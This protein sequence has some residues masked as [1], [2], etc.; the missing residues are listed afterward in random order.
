MKWHI[1]FIWFIN[2]QA[3]RPCFL[4]R[5]QTWITYGIKWQQNGVKIFLKLFLQ[6]YILL[7]LFSSRSTTWACH[8]GRHWRAALGGQGSRPVSSQGQAENGGSELYLNA[9]LHVR[10]LFHCLWTACSYY[11][12][13]HYWND[14]Q[15]WKQHTSP[16]INSTENGSKLKR[17][18]LTPPSDNTILQKQW[19]IWK[20]RSIM[21]FNY[22][23][24][25]GKQHELTHAS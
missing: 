10:N 8:L 21:Y 24:I 19:N 22:W 20:E 7:L 3:I 23:P 9:T 4:Y 2:Q 25:A 12:Q 15:S 16:R 6:N 13:G 18:Q 11:R 1:F 14:P 5:K 17:R